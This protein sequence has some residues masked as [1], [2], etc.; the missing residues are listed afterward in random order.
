MIEGIQNRIPRRR[1][2]EA[3][4]IG[5]LFALLFAVH[6]WADVLGL[7]G[8]PRLSPLVTTNLV[9]VFVLPALLVY[10]V[11]LALT[12]GLYARIRGVEIPVGLPADGSW[13]AAVGTLLTAPLLV[14][15]AGIAGHLVLDTSVSAMVQIRYSPDTRL[16]FLVL[17]SFVPAL[18]TGLGYG[19]LFFGVVHERLRD[20]TTPRHAVVLTPAVVGFFWKM[21][22]NVQSELLDPMALAHFAVLVAVSVGFGASL[23][24]LYQGVFRDSANDLVRAAY[25]PVFVLG[26]LGIVGV[27]SGFTFPTGLL[28]VLHLAAFGLA[29]YGYERTRSIW[30]PIFVVALFLAAVDAAAFTE[31]AVEFGGTL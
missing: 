19:F 1:N 9:D 11:G 15:V 31:T 20:V 21:Q 6:A 29:A 25:L 23:G 30:V 5:S 4:A 2:P 3:V 12:A 28:D 8:Y 27:I 13:R 7:V 18:F 16:S 14:A 10:G 26:L 24:L 17:S 22:G